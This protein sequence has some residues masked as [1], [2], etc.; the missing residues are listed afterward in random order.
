LA[1]CATQ[2]ADVS[3]AAGQRNLQLLVSFF[4]G[5]FETIAQTGARPDPVML[6]QAPIWP[7]VS[8]TERWLYVEYQREGEAQPFRQRIYR[9]HE[10]SG[11]ILITP[12]ELP[13]PATRFAGE[14]RK[15][16]P[17]A[18]LS[19]ADLRERPECRLIFLRQSEIPVFNGGTQGK[20]CRG[21]AGPEA[22][23]YFITSSSIRHRIAQET[24][25]EFRK[26]DEKLR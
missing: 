12:Y 19:P 18:R 2:P 20:D 1:A 26:I 14:W 21:E 6:R 22:P 5:T 10:S 24:P 4:A 25:W 9:F 16:A 23:E 3:T 7:G 13:S 8:A 17:F 15:P 11:A